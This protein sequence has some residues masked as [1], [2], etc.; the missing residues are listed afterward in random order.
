MRNA[1]TIRLDSNLEKLLERLCK[2]TGKS[3][4]ELVREALRRQMSLMRFERLRRQTMPFAEAR[5]YLTDEDIAR[6][7][8]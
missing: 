8:S 3:R 4:S 1:V 5:G 6:D 2:Q 7:A